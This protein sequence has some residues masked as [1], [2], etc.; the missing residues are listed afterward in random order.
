[1]SIRYSL[2]LLLCCGMVGCAELETERP[3]KAGVTFEIHKV[4]EEPTETTK[5]A[6]DP[7]TGDVLHLVTPPVITTAD[8]STG[9]VAEDENGMVSLQ[10]QLTAAGGQKIAD[11]T[12]VPG[13]RLAMV[14]NG[15]ITSAPN[16]ITQ[17]EAKFLVTGENNKAD[18][19][20]ILE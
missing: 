11:A 2:L 16:V 9:S 8:F 18:W 5:E 6:K 14:I 19:E 1:M 10:V 4:V 3:L 17:V 13:N 7:M 15:K 20:A 12:A